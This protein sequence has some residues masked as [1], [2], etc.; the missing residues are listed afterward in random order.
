MQEVEVVEI[1]P[2]HRR[3]WL[4]AQLWERLGA[5]FRTAY[6][7]WLRE[8]A[9]NPSARVRSGAAVTAGML[10]A[11]EPTTAER[12]LLRPWA[13][14]GRVALC[15][16]AGLAIGIPVLLGHDPAPSRALA[17][18]WSEPRNGAKRRR[19][20]I[21]A[22]G[23]PLG[24]WDSGSAAPAHL[25]QIPGELRERA[26]EEDDV[27]LASERALLR[28]AA[29]NALAGLVAAD[30]QA[31]QVRATVIGLLAA[32]AEE[33]QERRR[34]FELLPK[35]VHRLTR[36]DELARASL[37]AL[38]GDAE[39]A[40]FSELTALLARAFDVPLGSASAR[41]ALLVL[42]DALGADRINQEVVNTVIRAMKAGARPGR[43]S[44]LGQQL[45]RVLSVERRYDN[46]RGRAAY[47]VYATFFPIPKE[48]LNRAG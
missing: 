4:F 47:A 21:A 8:L 10:F 32:Q 15:E 12:E 40:S 20:A 5:D 14:D 45:E 26:P 17:Y 25:W 43:L 9:G 42:L 27:R 46:A 23:G 30:A 31:G 24:A 33:R 29:D 22:Y 16:C 18:A 37:S 2:P 41:A 28:R 36:G 35:I 19:A 1:C 39:L 7:G 44:K 48:V 34:A 6:I 13:L 3:E 38:L 11:K